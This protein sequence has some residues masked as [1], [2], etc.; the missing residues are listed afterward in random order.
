MT[1]QLALPTPSAITSPADGS[2]ADNPR[3]APAGSQRPRQFLSET[4]GGPSG[5]RSVTTATRASASGR[6]SRQALSA[7]VASASPAVFTPAQ[8]R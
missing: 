6:A 7:P 4:D 3:L 1:T 2:A 8:P 5:I